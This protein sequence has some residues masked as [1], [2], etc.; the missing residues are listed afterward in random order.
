ML[1]STSMYAR[2]S[3]SLLLTIEENKIRSVLFYFPILFF[4]IVFGMR[5]GVGGDHLQY[6]SRYED[7][8]RGKEL[9]GEVL[10]NWVTAIFSRNGMHFV[11]YFSFLAFVQILLLFLSFKKEPY[12]LPFLIFVLFTGG[13]YLT[14][15]NVIRQCLVLCMFIYSIKFIRLQKFVPFISIILIGIFIH[16]SAIILI[17]VY[18]I[19][20][21]ERDFFKNR[22]IQF[23]LLTFAFIM[24]G[25]EAW[26][27]SFGDL[28][29]LLLFFGYKKY[30]L[31]QINSLQ[32]AADT[33]IGVILVFLIDIIII[34]YSTK[35]KNTFKNS[36]FIIFYNLYFAGRF[37]SL[38][39]FGSILFQRPLLYFF[40]LKLVVVSYLLYYLSKNFKTKFN[41][42]IFM[43]LVS[44]YF[45]LFIGLLSKG[46]FNTSKFVFF[47]DI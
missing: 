11:L 33:G 24:R 36:N 15:M 31:D 45:L 2:S 6:L 37:L 38:L 29:S 28:N 27:N 10:F 9:N 4:A 44:C 1:S 18:P 8:G 46:E 20:K 14:W 43:I 42:L 21:G 17:L 32:V 23:L 47:W 34:I 26:M 3:R 39:F 5:Y 35:L 22:A 40:T 16:K 13:Y 19:L 30:S 25:F 7:I 41:T 12:L